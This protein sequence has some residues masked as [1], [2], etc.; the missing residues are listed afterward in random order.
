MKAG[1]SAFPAFVDASAGR[2]ENQGDLANRQEHASLTGENSRLHANLTAEEKL[3]DSFSPNL[4]NE[5]NSF[6][7]FRSR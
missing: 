3:P 1:N 2:G 6:G 4:T 5:S 7:R